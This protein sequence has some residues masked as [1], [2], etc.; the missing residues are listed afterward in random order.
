MHPPDPGFPPPSSDPAE[1]P[2]HGADAALDKIGER[3]QNYAMRLAYDGSSFQGWQVQPHG[4]SIQGRLEEALR[5]L[6]RRPVKVYGSGRTDAGVHALGQ[7]ANFR[8]PPG[9]DLRKLRASLNGLAGPFISVQAVVPIAADFHARHSAR[10]K[11]YRYQLYNRP[12]PPLFAPQCTWW[13]RQPLDVAAMRAAAAPLLG[14]HDFSAF[15]ARA[16]EALH[17]VRTL[18]RLDVLPAAAPDCTLAIELE[19]NGF[20]QHMAR[21]LTGT[22][23]EVGLGRLAP[24]EVPRILASR[25]RERAPATAPPGGLHLLHVEYDLERFPELRAFEEA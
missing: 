1:P 23:V 14:E 20:L 22:L 2:G 5:I 16:C 25:Q 17:P 8:L 11:R 21:I 6:A 18:R 10:G 4:P 12:Y 19:A 13:L 7:V 15:R 9:Q 24:E 3:L